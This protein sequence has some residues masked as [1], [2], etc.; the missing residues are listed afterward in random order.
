ML[1]YVLNVTIALLTLLQLALA[2]AAAAS[3]TSGLTGTLV[4]QDHNGGTIYLYDLAGKK[5]KALTEGYDPALSPDGSTVAFIRYGGEQGLYLIDANGMNE[6]RIYGGSRDL[7]APSWSP[8][9]SYI[10][11]SRVNGEDRCRQMGPRCVPDRPGLEDFPLVI[12]DKRDLS[13]VNTD[14]GDFQD[15]P[16]METAN[17]PDWN[18]AGIVYAAA[19]GL[20]ITAEAPNSATRSLLDARNYSA[21]DPDWQPNGGRIVFQRKEGTHWEIFAVNPDGSGL[22]ALTRPVSVLVET[23]PQNV[24]PAWSPDGSSIVYLSNRDAKNSAGAWRLWVMNADGSNQRLLDPD[25]LGKIEFDYET[26]ADQMVG[27]S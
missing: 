2:P 8:D 22:T 15:I 3:K 10:V 21:Q 4:F 17:A 25:V 1:N 7:R 12:V 14:G 11:F 5:L 6:R 13:R 19:E 26:S 24:S 20:Q 18:T 27:W 23:L 16:T 9:G